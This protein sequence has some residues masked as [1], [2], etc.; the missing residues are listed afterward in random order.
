MDITQSVPKMNLKYDSTYAGFCQINYTSR[1]DGQTFYYCLQEIGETVVFHRCS[2]DWEPQWEAN[3]AIIASIEVPPESSP[4][5]R[6][7]YEKFTK[8]GY[9]GK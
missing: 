1:L 5:A 8:G 3:K 7:I 2:R 4:Y 9:H 6:E